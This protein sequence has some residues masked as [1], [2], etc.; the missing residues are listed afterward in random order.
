MIRLYRA[1]FSTNVERVALALAHKGLEAESVVI[2]PSDR[3]LVERVSGQGLVPVIDWDGRVVADSMAIICFLEERE[4]D[5]PL[6]PSDPAR[7]AEMDIFIDWFNRVWK[8]PPNAIEAELGKPEPDAD[9]IADWSAE[10]AAALETFEAMLAGRDHLM[11]D[12]FSA[13]DCCAFPFVKYALRRDP[14]DSELFHVVLDEHQTLTEDH[15][16][17]REWIGR[18]DGRP[19]A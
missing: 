11:G 7:R 5:P 6:F 2:D 10:M 14:A 19:R 8:L 15:P 12:E 16:R 17:L 9:R 18:V 1:H 4:P 3:S 13:A